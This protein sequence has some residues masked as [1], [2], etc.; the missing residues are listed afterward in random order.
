VFSSDLLEGTV[1]A[2]EFPAGLD[3]L[4][5]S[6]PLRLKDLRGKFV[7][8]DFWTYCCI[9]CMHILPDL[10]RLETKY[11]QELVVI[12]VHS[13]KFKNEK[14]TS[15]IRSA[16]LRYEIHHPVVNDSNFQVWQSFGVSSW[17][18]I[19]LINPAG[20]I[21]AQ[22]PG[23]GVFEP[24]D[25][26][27]QQAIPHFAA[28]G[29]LKRSPLKLSLEEARK[30]NT[31][32]EFPGKI[33]SDEK[34]NRLFITDSNHNRIVITNGSGRI[35][36]VIGSG[37]EG[38]KDGS[39]E[40]AQFHHPQ[41]TVAVGDVLYIT[42]TE[43]HLVRA[44][45]L[46]SRT[47]KS[48]LGTGQ[49]A[50]GFN[51]P[52]RGL[53][54]ALSSPWDLVV[55]DDKIYIAM[56]GFHQLW[57]ADLQTWDARP[58]AGSGRENIEDDKLLNAA[59]AQPSGITTDGKNLYFADSETSSIRQ[60]GLSPGGSVHTI[61]GKGLFEFGDVD[62]EASSA[63]LQH[64]LGVVYH[65]G[66]LYVA[67]TY[68]SK[69]K[70]V[71]PARRT[72]K[73]LAGSGMKTLADGKFPT[74]AFDEPGGIAWLGGKLYVADT[75][76]HQVRVLDPAAKSVSTLEFTGLEE[77]S[78]RQMDTFRGR[79]LDLGQKELKVGMGKL[80][81]NVVLPQGYKFNREAPFFMRWESTNG[82]RLKFGLKPDAVDFKKATFPLA[83]P[84]QV[85]AGRSELN[86][87]TVVYY[88]TEKSTLCLV[89]PIRV[90]LAL[91]GAP[92]GP[93]EVPVEISVKKPGA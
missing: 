86:I 17:P 35:L 45:D 63:R 60:A 42:D 46:R 14:D 57:V 87:D 26:V 64:P 82:S 5:T 11:S 92:D 89:D 79:I 90:K 10:E 78:R 43:N 65:D 85:P 49:Q 59:L 12:G 52:G 32:L 44:A 55:R 33:S 1:N 28:K 3:W 21:V 93:A 68:N 67:D 50:R 18:T 84:V 62:G 39:F 15:Q 16:I 38:R 37:D 41:G 19:V 74:A 7:L 2:P 22:R 61:L 80:S 88:C 29:Q 81:L 83:L 34:S 36:D 53:G 54:V 73:T 8:L 91:V 58:Y 9:N 77:L 6:T 66:L 75:N 27:L 47:V 24:F 20:K 13:A 51:Q 76:N 30:A 31:L 23:E 71:D 70:V 25:A 4:N 69:I 56:A 48:V 40:E 72:V